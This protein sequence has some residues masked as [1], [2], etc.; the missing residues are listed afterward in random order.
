M[1]LVQLEP[2]LLETLRDRVV[3]LTG[4]AIGI[5]RSAVEQFHAAGAKVVFGDI[6]DEPGQDLESQLGR[7]R[8]RYVHCD[9]TSYADQLHLFDTAEKEFGR[10]DV[11]VSNAAIAIH[12]DV[13]VPEADVTVEPS[14]KEIDVNLKG[15]LFTARIGMHYLRKDKTPEG[16]GGDL[17]LVSSI[18]GFKESGGL[19]TYTASKHGVLGILRGLRVTALPENIRI[20]AICPWMT[21]TRMVRGIEK[22]WYENNLP[23]NEPA[24]VARA[25]VICA[26]ANRSPDKTTIHPGARLPFAGKILWVGGGKAYEI[27]DRLQELEPEWLGKENSAVLARGQAFLASEGTS[28]DVEKL[29]NGNGN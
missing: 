7:A 13:F 20:N 28:W 10:V 2:S 4:G 5:G 11:V 9:T 27:E 26:T 21:K 19:V 18:A 12:K 17:V 8:V 6:Q 1:A 22:G 3:V 29:K 15:A 25:I 14:M 24:D 16:P 23:T